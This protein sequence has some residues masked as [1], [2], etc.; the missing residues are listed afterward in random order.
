MFDAEAAEKIFNFAENVIMKNTQF[1]KVNYR[2][3]MSQT[4][5]TPADYINT[6]CI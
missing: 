6:I 5:I 2:K 1:S 4:G 3:M